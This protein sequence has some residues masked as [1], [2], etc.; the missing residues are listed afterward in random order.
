MQDMRQDWAQLKDSG[1]TGH[2][3]KDPGRL[4]GLSYETTGW[5]SKKEQGLTLDQIKEQGPARGCM[6]QPCLTGDH[7]QELVGAWDVKK[8]PGQAWD[9]IL[10]PRA[11]NNFKKEPCPV[12]YHIQDQ[13]AI[14]YFKKRQ[15]GV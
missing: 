1:T 2:F 12:L 15:E 7:M 14:G 11:T 4:C 9:C 6:K 3:R 10:E 5:D 13:G 8:E